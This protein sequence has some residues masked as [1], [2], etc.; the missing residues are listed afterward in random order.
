MVYLTNFIDFCKCMFTQNL[1]PA[2]GE[3][4]QMTR[5]VAE[6]SKKHQFETFHM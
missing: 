3:G 4:Q 1:M 2:V 6:C 5:K